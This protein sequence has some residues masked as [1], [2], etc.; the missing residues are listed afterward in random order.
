MRTGFE[1]KYILAL[2]NIVSAL[3]NKYMSFFINYIYRNLFSITD[4]FYIDF[5][6]NKI[7]DLTRD[8]L[9]LSE[10]FNVSYEYTEKL[11]I[12]EYYKIISNANSILKERNAK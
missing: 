6:A 7:K 2:I 1:C 10:N 12:Q 11:S 4:I 5:M 8:R 9:L 3:D